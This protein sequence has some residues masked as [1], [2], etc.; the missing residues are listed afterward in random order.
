MVAGMEAE[1]TVVFP[2]EAEAVMAV[3]ADLVATVQS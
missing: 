1:Y 2:L 3:L